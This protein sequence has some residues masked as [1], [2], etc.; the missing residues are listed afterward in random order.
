MLADRE[1][2]M[3]SLLTMLPEPSRAG[4][5]AAEPPP[6]EVAMGR[7]LIFLQAALFHQGRSI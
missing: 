4:T 5:A 6:E 3:L 1:L 2:T 7:T